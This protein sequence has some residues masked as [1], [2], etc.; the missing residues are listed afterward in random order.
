MKTVF[1]ME[2]IPTNSNNAVIFSSHLFF[3]KYCKGVLYFLKNL[4][5]IQA[6]ANDL[7][8]NANRT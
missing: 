7:K 1:L 2:T 3:K 4:Q 5:I 6:Y 8:E